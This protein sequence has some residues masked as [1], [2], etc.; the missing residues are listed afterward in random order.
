MLRQ[1]MMNI[2]LA[3]V[4]VGAVLVGYNAF[5]AKNDNKSTSDRLAQYLNLDVAKQ[6]KSEDESLAA[7]TGNNDQTT[8]QPTE[9]TDQP[10]T[11]ATGSESATP[12][13]ATTPASN[14]AES[15]YTVKEGDTYGCIAEKY[16]GSFEHWVD[17]M[18]ANPVGQVGFTEYGLHV[19]AQ[20][21]LPAITA[22][23]LKSAS[24]LCS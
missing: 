1:N 7:V 22:T 14:K 24:N 23:H 3:V 9:S 6:E 11:P 21:V 8:A 12:Q 15:V 5:V 4:A 19:G 2:L 20:I 13:A 18:N 17:V 16:Y 10:A